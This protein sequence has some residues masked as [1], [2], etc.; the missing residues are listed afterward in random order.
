MNW[1]IFSIIPPALWAITNHIDKFMLSRYFK[2]REGGAFMLFTSFFGILVAGYIFI[3]KA[4]SIEISFPS[5]L[6]IMASGAA[7]LGSGYF[8]LKALSKAE[9]S[10]VVPMFQVVAIF[11]YFLGLFFLNEHLTVLQIIACALVLL[12]S[13]ALALE[14]IE[15]KIRLKMSVVW[16]MLVCTIITAV[17]G[18]AFKYVAIESNYWSTQAW[19]WLGLFLAGLIIFLLNKNWRDTFLD[20]LGQS[21]VK[22]LGITAV[23]EILNVTAGL[24]FTY[25]ILLMPLAVVSVVSNGL[26]PFFVFFFGIIITIFIPRFGK[27]NIAKN[28]LLQRIIAIATI[29]LGTFLL[30]R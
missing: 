21:K 4:S 17:N 5:T 1:L 14:S 3:F 18:L 22:V 27:E 28:H 6:I 23:N 30:N 20:I 16:P 7:S 29:F 13:M 25:A 12:G 11:R 10:I 15:K 9:P 2:G 8:Y 24:I 19:D 26:Q